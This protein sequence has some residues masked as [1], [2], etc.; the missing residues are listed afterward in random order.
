MSATLATC[1][2]GCDASISLTASGGTGT[3]LF[4]I[5]GGS[6]QNNS[7][8]NNLCANNYTVV[9]SDVVG[10]T[11]STQISVNTVNGP[12]LS[13]VAVNQIPCYGAANGSISLT[14]SGGTSPLNYT[15][16]P[17]SNTNN[18]GVF[19][20]LTPNTYTVQVVDANGCSIVTVATIV[21]PTQMQF[22]NVSST[23][24]LCNGVNNGS[25]SFVFSGGTGT[26]NFSILPAGT[27]TAPNA[28]TGL[29][30]NQTY[31]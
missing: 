3:L 5:N 28:F 11:Y 15:L 16:N 24:A 13:N 9:V 6:F 23:S 2:P 21:Q 30:G 14:V 10:C 26:S 8:F 4:A 19:N 18:N 29:A 27:F 7:V 17:G 22:S 31:T 25:I 12:V 1:N 20:A